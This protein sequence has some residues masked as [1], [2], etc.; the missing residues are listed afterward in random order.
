M[1]VKETPTKGPAS[2]TSTPYKIFENESLGLLGLVESFFVLHGTTDLVAPKPTNIFFFFFGFSSR[3]AREK[4]TAFMLVYRFFF[5]PAW[6]FVMVAC[7][8]FAACVWLHKIQQIDC[9]QSME[10]KLLCCHY[11]IHGC[12]LAMS[13][14]WC[15]GFGPERSDG[16]WHKEG[17]HPPSPH[18]QGEL[19]EHGLGAKRLMNE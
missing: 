14:V 7:R 19:K 13:D 2:G 9:G 1:P 18:G 4:Q 10:G 15:G 6:S 8:T 17:I 12:S 3:K 11:A 5:K 16:T